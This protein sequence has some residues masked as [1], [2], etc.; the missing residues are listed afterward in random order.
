MSAS[1][2][3]GVHPVVVAGSVA[4]AHVAVASAVVVHQDS[5]AHLAVCHVVH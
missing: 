5:V 4:E 2:A 1:Q 3:E